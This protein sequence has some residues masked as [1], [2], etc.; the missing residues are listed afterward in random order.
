[1]KEI[2]TSVLAYP[3]FSLTFVAIFGLFRLR[4]G[5]FETFFQSSSPKSQA[6][7]RQVILFFLS[8][9]N[10]YVSNI[11]FKMRDDEL[12]QAFEPYGEIVSSKIIMDRDTGRSRGF[13]FVEFA[14]REDGQAALDALNGANLA[15]KEIAVSEA[16]PR[17][18]RPQ[19]GGQRGGFGG[20]DRGGYS[21]GGRY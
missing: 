7:K 13:G 21:R 14:N 10:L 16:R 19:G 15:G 20:G 9:M 12:R 18:E 3:A 11:A 8:I 2:G 5:R 17:E 6:P 1:M 4:N